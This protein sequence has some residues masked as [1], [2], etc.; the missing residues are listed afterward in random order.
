MNRRNFIK[1]GAAAGV[2]MGAR[3][4]AAELAGLDD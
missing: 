1:L 3:A 2:L 4:G